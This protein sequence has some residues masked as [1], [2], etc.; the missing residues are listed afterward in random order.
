MEEIA[1][2]LNLNHVNLRYISTLVYPLETTCTKD[3]STHN[4]FSLSSMP[5][6]NAIRHAIPFGDD[7]LRHSGGLDLQG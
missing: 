2:L 4:A 7:L 1:E 5:R 3:K 6:N